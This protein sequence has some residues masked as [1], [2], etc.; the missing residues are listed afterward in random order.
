[1]QDNP[2]NE[3]FLNEAWE[4]MRSQLDMVMPVENRRRLLI[5]WWLSGAAVMLILLAT[6]SLNGTK[7]VEVPLTT[8]ETNQVVAEASTPNDQKQNKRVEAMVPEAGQTAATDLAQNIQTIPASKSNDSPEQERTASTAKSSLENESTEDIPVEVKSPK[9]QWPRIAL[10]PASDAEAVYIDTLVL[11]FTPAKNS[12]QAKNSTN[13]QFTLL[14]FSEVN[15]E[16]KLGQLSPTIGMGGAYSLGRFSLNVASGIQWGRS[17]LDFRSQEESFLAEAEQDN[18]LGTSFQPGFSSADPQDIDFRY[19]NLRFP[20]SIGYQFGEKWTVESG[21]IWNNILHFSAIN[22]T[23]TDIYRSYQQNNA[24]PTA[25]ATESG[26][27][28]SLLQRRN[29]IQ[30]QIGIQYQVGEQWQV[31]AI[32]Q[33]ALHPVLAYDQLQWNRNYATVG[34]RYEINSYISGKK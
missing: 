5:G 2:F 3:A 13:P 12:S 1:M 9:K 17:A 29:F 32:Y 4:D 30:G 28:T 25:V 6:W 33:H 8:G 15:F 16:P 10:L 24:N 23:D 7:E 31:Y 20:V 26:R 34:L 14:A 22:R 11:N 18:G 21:I 27:L 19:M